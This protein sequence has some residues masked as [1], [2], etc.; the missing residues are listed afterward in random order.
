MKKQEMAIEWFNST[1]RGT[2][3]GVGELTEAF[4]GIGLGG[5]GFGPVVSANNN[6]SISLLR[7]R[8]DKNNSL[9]LSRT[10]QS[11]TKYAFMSIEEKIVTAY[12][13]N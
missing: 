3:T 5:G 7:Y 2:G 12:A 6:A 9:T 4:G 10:A 1:K 13:N 8:Y 11:C